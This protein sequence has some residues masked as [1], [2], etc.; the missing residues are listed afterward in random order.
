MPALAGLESSSQGA[1][2][3]NGVK[4]PP[5]GVDES[6]LRATIATQWGIEVES[7]S[8][9]AVGGGSHHWLVRTPDTGYRFLTVDDLSTKPWLGTG[10]DAAFSGLD[11]AYGTARLLRD[12]GLDFVVAPIPAADGAMLVRLDERFSAALFPYIAGRAGTFG[13]PF[14]RRDHHD[15][16]VLWARLHMSTELVR[17]RAP[18]RS[19]DVPGRPA[20][21]EA[22]GS[23]RGGPWTGGPYSERVRQWL[24]A[25][26]DVVAAGLERYDRLARDLAT[27]DLVITHGE[28]HGGN[29]IRAEEGLRLIDW[30]TVALAPR[31]RDLWMLGGDLSAY[32]EA[33]GRMVDPTAIE[34]YRLGWLVTDVAAFV[35]QL[36]EPH[37]ENADSAHAWRALSLTGESLSAGL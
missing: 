31:E 2:A 4:S 27:K 24:S 5:D 14:T 1:D 29:L 20:L 22:L 23:D 9:E 32:V 34:F 17:D 21:D 6:A 36:R 25:H 16:C 13:E 19:L 11:L 3:S 37:L 15:L 10:H 18:Q 7:V 35:S 28:P 12:S 33:T 8:Y 26:G 30:D